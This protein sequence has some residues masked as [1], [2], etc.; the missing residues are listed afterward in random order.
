MKKIVGVLI[1]TCLLCANGCSNKEDNKHID[2]VVENV[3]NK[4]EYSNI[5]YYNLLTDNEKV[6]YDLLNEASIQYQNY[7]TGDFAF[8]NDEFN[9]A[10]YAFTYDWPIY[11]WWRNGIETSYNNKKFTST[12]FEDGENLEK[13]VNL[14]IEKGKEIAD[15][16][17]DDNTYKNIKNIHDYV[18][19]MCDYEDE[20]DGH[21]L[22]GSLINNECVCDGYAL[23]FKY[24]CNESKINC[25]V[26]DGQAIDKSGLVQHAWNLVELNNKWYGVDTTWDDQTYQNSKNNLVYDYCL[27]SDKILN[28]DHFPNDKYSLPKCDDASLYYLNVPGKYYDNYNEEDIKEFLIYWLNNGNTDFYLKFSNYDDGAKAYSWLIEDKAFVNIYNKSDAPIS[29]FE[30]GCYFNS[31]SYILHVY[32]KLV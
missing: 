19:Q 21:N 26:V 12:S 11:Y 7:I 24:I 16:C 6:Y 23:A 13:N 29:N 5:Y 4:N 25:I 8:N 14:I 18:I 1:I 31:T 10:L 30:Y 20:N 32:Y 22:Y 17:R 2:I 9:N 3:D 28:A 27:T 15:K